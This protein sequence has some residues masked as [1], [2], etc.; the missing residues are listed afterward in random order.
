MDAFSQAGV[1]EDAQLSNYVRSIL[2][3]QVRNS[4]CLE[5]LHGTLNAN[6]VTGTTNPRRTIRLSVT[7]PKRFWSLPW[8]K[9]GTSPVSWWG[10]SSRGCGGLCL[11]A[12]RGRAG[13]AAADLPIDGVQMRTSGQPLTVQSS[14]L[15]MSRC[16]D[17]HWSARFLSG[18]E[19]ES[20]E[21][22]W[23][24]TGSYTRC[25][26]ESSDTTSVLFV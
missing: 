25:G 13:A 15:D 10:T 1:V 19:L 12:R 14:V 4:Q 20:P 16:F 24:W 7:T 11:R 23:T 2:H 8:C 17:E 6:T 22:G 21:E 18:N 5:A 26:K 3:Q 9:T